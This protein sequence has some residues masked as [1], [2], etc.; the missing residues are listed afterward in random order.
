VSAWTPPYCGVT[1]LQGTPKGWYVTVT[2]WPGANAAE[3]YVVLPGGG[4]THEFSA[5]GFDALDVVKR[6][7][8]VFVATIRGGAPMP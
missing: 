1:H 2:D 7:L 4:F 6:R 5:R 8:E 3:G